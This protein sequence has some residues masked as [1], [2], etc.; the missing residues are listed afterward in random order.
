MDCTEVW[1]FE[2]DLMPLFAD[3]REFRPSNSQHHYSFPTGGQFESSFGLSAA[4]YEACYTPL[5]CGSFGVSGLD[6]LSSSRTSLGSN[7]SNSPVDDSIF[8][9]MSTMNHMVENEID[10]KSHLCITSCHESTQDR[11]MLNYDYS[12]GNYAYGSLEFHDDFSGLPE[13]MFDDL[14]E[15]LLHEMAFPLPMTSSP[16]NFVEPSKTFK[17]APYRPTT[18]KNMSRTVLGSPLEEYSDSEETITYFMSPRETHSQTPS[19]SISSGSRSS[20][21][22]TLLG[23]T[24]E[25]SVALHRIQSIG[26]SR[27]SKRLKRSPQVASKID[28]VA[29]GAFRCDYPGCKSEH[30]FKRH[31]HLKRHQRTHGAQKLLQ[32]RFCPK[33]FQLDRS[34][35]YRSHVRLHSVDRKGSRTEYFPEAIHEVNSW[36][37]R[38]EADKKLGVP[39]EMYRVYSRRVTAGGLLKSKL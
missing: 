26:S 37:K 3:Q 19:S 21:S 4:S 22:T 6:G 11:N 1:K 29:A 28:R 33:N 38:G 20:S 36:K 35:N 15:V 30:G 17:I 39:G 12:Q 13:M 2:D 31:E 5:V 25:S 7:G 34:D 10:D 23:Q 9:S 18:P 14:T 32:C 27:I 16:D 8:Y 24:L